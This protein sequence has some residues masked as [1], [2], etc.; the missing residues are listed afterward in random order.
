MSH[1][2]VTKLNTQ[3]RKELIWIPPTH[4]PFH[5]LKYPATIN[6]SVPSSESIRSRLKRIKPVVSYYCNNC[7]EEIW[8][9]FL[10]IHLHSEKPLQAQSLVPHLLYS[11]FGM[12]KIVMPGKKTYHFHG[13][14]ERNGR[15]LKDRLQHLLLWTATQIEIAKYQRH[16]SIKWCRVYDKK[17]GCGVCKTRL[18]TNWWWCKKISGIHK[19]PI[20]NN[21]HGHVNSL[22]YI[23]AHKQFPG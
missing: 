11:F 20:E 14:E 19:F 1:L 13:K 12:H 4:N 9:D 22:P 17:L 15:M 3:L 2:Q 6:G 16:L 7:R 10:Y 21:M 8:K 23:L 18:N 5:S